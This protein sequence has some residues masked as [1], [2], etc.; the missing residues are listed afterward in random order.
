LYETQ[1]LIANKNISIFFKTKF[2][3]IFKKLNES[4]IWRTPPQLSLNYFGLLLPLMMIG[5]RIIIF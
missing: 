1:N 3:F 2:F 4:S 5:S